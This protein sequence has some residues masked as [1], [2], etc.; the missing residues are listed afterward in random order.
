MPQDIMH[1][2]FEDVLHLEVRLMLKHFLHVEHYFTLDTLNTRIENFAYGSTEARNKPPKPFSSG[3]I[4]GCGKLP[5]SGSKACYVLVCLFK[6]INFLYMHVYTAAQ[7][8]T[9][10][11]L[12]PLFVGD[13]IPLEQPQW[14]CYLL[15]PLIVKQCTARLMS[16]SSSA[17]LAAL[18]HQH[19]QSFKKCYPDVALTPKMHYMVHFPSQL[20]E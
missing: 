14:E 8:W 17:Y 12:L 15:L 20:L 3:H 19:H 11:T 13:L 1:V 9:F 10:A 5:L 2:L 18:V 4:T 6:L 7:M 16:V